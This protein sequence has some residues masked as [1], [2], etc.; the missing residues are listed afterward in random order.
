MRKTKKIKVGNIFVGGGAPVSVQS[1]LCTPNGDIEAATEQTSRLINA[2]CQIL[3]LAVP[4]EKM[5]PVIYAL[6]EKFDLPL[7]AD[8]HF[9]YKLAIESIAAGVDKVRINPGNIGADDC[10]KKVVNACRTKNIPIRIGVNGGSL[11][12]NILQKYGAPTAD[13]MVESAL[14]HIR[15]LEKFDF[16]DIAISIKSSNVPNMVS[17]YRSLAEKCDYPFHI[18][19]TEAGPGNRGIIKNSIGI[20]ALL[21]DGI[22]DTLRVSLTDDPVNEVKVGYDILQSVGLLPGR[23]QLISCPTCGRCNVDIISL[24]HQME[25]KLTSVSKPITVAIMG[26][27]VNGPGEAREADIGV[28]GGKGE[29]L[30]FKKGEIIGKV[31]QDQIIT[32]LME[33]IESL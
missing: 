32:R 15:L 25:E 23:P 22:G 31:P 27:A 16:E 3:R 28:A 24:A 19:V 21:L 17:A 30:I 4:D 9:D 13:A 5:L 26:C 29:G 7:V 12:K 11:E 6:K 20:G 33:E 1:M 8:I 14:Y 18:G 10:V 2:G